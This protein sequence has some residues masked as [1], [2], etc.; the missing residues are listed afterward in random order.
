MTVFFHETQETIDLLRRVVD[1]LDETNGCI[2][3]EEL[4]EGV[5]RYVMV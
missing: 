5:L 4:W 1:N 2:S 3:A